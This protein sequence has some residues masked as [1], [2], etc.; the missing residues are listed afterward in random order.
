MRKDISILVIDKAF[1]EEGKFNFD[2]KSHIK[3]LKAY[4]YSVTETPTAENLNQE[5]EII[6]AHPLWEEIS[7]LHR[8]HEEHPKIPIIFYS[9]LAKC[10]SN[11]KTEKSKF[12][13]FVT[14]S[15]G[16][17]YF[18]ISSMQ[19]F[20]KLIKHLSSEIYRRRV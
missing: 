15:N 20:L 1:F 13:G 5:Y 12:G 19:D 4:C 7:S 9:L 6:V 2:L 14:D 11:K 17:Y 3:T 10:D 18:L 8:Y 16:A